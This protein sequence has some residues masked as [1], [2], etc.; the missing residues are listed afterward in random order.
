[1]PQDATAFARY[2]A[3]TASLCRRMPDAARYAQPLLRRL[4]L[5]PPYAAAVVSRRLPCAPFSRL[6]CHF[7]A[8]GCS[9]ML[10]PSSPTSPLRRATVSAE[11]PYAKSAFS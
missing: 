1:M 8:R 5:L 11:P 6:I 9:L 7:P 10:P 4:R 2:G 3:T